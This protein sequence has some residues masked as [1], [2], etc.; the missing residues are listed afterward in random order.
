MPQDVIGRG[1]ELAAIDRVLDRARI[2]LSGLLL[3]GDP[4]IGE[5]TLWEAARV[6]AFDRGFA[7]LSSRPACSESSLALAAFGD[8]FSDVPREIIDRLPDPQ[9]HAVD[10][11]LLRTEP[12]GMASDQ[13]V[14]GVATAS[15]VPRPTWAIAAT[16]ARRSSCRLERT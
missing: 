4:G 1:A 15:L 14:L 10:I 11:A 7:V 13:R 3:R 2:N 6:A 8:L 5:T 9:R 16:V 12:G